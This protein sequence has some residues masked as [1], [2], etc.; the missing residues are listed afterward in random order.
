MGEPTDELYALRPHIDPL[1]M[2]H[3]RAR[4]EQRLFG[5]ATSANVGR[6]LLLGK[7]GNGGMGVVHSAYDPELHRKVA[8]KILHP[9][10]PHERARER[11]IAEARALA[12]LD[13]PNVVKVHDVLDY[14][15]HVVLV[16]EWVEGDTL[17]AWQ[18]AAPRSWQAVLPVY[19]QAAQGLAAAHGVGVIHR[20][21]KPANAILGVDGRVRVLDFGLARPVND[22][23]SAAVH[24][25]E[26]AG[27][28]ARSGNPTGAVHET[29]PS[30]TATGALVGTLAYASPEQLEGRAVTAASDQFSFA[31]SLHRAIEGV[32]PY[33]GEAVASRLEAIRTSALVLASDGRTVPTWLRR[34]VARSLAADPRER[35]PSMQAMIAALTRPRGWR[36][37]R[38]PV[39]IATLVAVSVVAVAT[40]G[41]SAALAPCDGGVSDIDPIWSAVIRSRIGAAFDAVHA[42]W[43]RETRDLALQGLDDYRTRW[44]NAHRNA[45]LA[46]RRGAQSEALLDRRMLCLQRRRVDL[47]NAVSVMA[48]LDAGAALHAV[49]LVARLPAINDCADVE[50][51]EAQSP[52]PP[53]AVEGDVAR[54]RDRLSQAVAL[55]RIGRNLEA[56][57]LATA[58]SAEAERIGYAQLVADVALARGRML[59]A[60]GDMEPATAALS[61]SLEA[62]LQHHE[63]AV[64]VEA[65]ARRI[66][67][68][69]VVNP[70]LAAV[71]RDAGFLLPLS[72]GLPGDHFVRPLLLNNLG[73]AHI[74]AGDPD[75]AHRYFQ[76]A[77]DALVGVGDVDP[78]L[79]C[80]DLNLARL[81]KDAQA[82]EA[83]ARGAWTRRRTALGD[84]NLETLDA[85]STYARLIPDPVRALPLLGQACDAYSQVHPELIWARAYCNGYRGFLTELLGDRDGALRIY[86]SVVAFAEHDD[87][88]DAR[89]QA[90]LARGSAALLRGEAVAAIAAWQHLAD[91]EARSP[92]WWVRVRAGQ[93]ELGLG[94]ASRLLHRDAEARRHFERALQFFREAAAL[95]QETQYRVRLDLAQR[96]RR[97]TPGARRRRGYRS[98]NRETQ[99][100]RAPL[101]GHAGV[102]QSHSFRSRHFQLARSGEAATSGRC[103]VSMHEQ[104]AD[105]QSIP[106]SIAALGDQS[107]PPRYTKVPDQEHQEFSHRDR[108]DR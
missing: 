67:T 75:Q 16:M 106:I 41:G 69:G 51:L 88:E 58:V 90:T 92:H 93:A 3:T 27:V 62:A 66:Y 10:G 48:K 101:R 26:P 17:A 43:V 103:F 37:L 79:T 77:H 34:I 63:L 35:F 28:A 72:I 22:A 107:G 104:L 80:I 7:T 89:A 14:S 39:A 29:W 61:R 12:K 18:D 99:S 57:T 24:A 19:A 25:A 86:D 102:H 96:G 59:L 42:S 56:V 98:T 11:L 81:T 20:D 4:A 40:R 21:F 71:T 45:C 60:K 38:V 105:H 36:R 82:R 54:V 64:A 85:L 87:D 100:G 108:A 55:D 68:E 94:T 2:A 31:V 46:H 9:R 44:I 52:R 53:A 73:S 32:A 8:L 50:R 33:A 95:D 5:S 74:A 15:D 23:D 91:V 1:D 30:L 49:E 47:Q 13:H 84:V 83:L 97:F 78:E 6:Y 65:G 76:Q 70:D